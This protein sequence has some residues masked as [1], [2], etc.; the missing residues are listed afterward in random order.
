MAT[1][2]GALQ[3][4]DLRDVRQH[5][6]YHFTPWLAEPTN[7]EVLGKMDAAFRPLIKP[8]QI[9]DLPPAPETASPDS[10]ALTD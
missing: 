3:R 6:Q 7:L 9:S 2:L 8:L 10:G 5:E 4:V 1:Q